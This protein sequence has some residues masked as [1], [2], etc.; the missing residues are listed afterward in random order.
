MKLDELKAIV[1]GMGD[2]ENSEVLIQRFDFRRDYKEVEIFLE[3]KI[4]DGQIFDLGMKR[5]ELVNE[6]TCKKFYPKKH[7]I[8]IFNLNHAY[9]CNFS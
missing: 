4:T 2:L 6:A 9:D 1:L 5:K 3:D 8:F 7:M